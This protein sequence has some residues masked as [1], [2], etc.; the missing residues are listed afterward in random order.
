MS[1]LAMLKNKKFLHLDLNNF[2]NWIKI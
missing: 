1:Y 2:Q